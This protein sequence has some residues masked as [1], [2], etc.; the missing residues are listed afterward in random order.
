MTTI[1]QTGR[2]KQSK[3]DVKQNL[4]EV[5]F[6][7]EK[8]TVFKTCPTCGYPVTTLKKDEQG[9]QWYICGKEK[10][11]TLTSKPQEMILNDYMPKGA[12]NYSYDIEGKKHFCPGIFARE[13]MNHVFF[14]TDELTDQTYI[15]NVAK[16]IWEAN[17]EPF[18][19]NLM[20][21]KLKSA[22][23]KHQY[24]EVI[25]NIKAN[26]YENVAESQN[27]IALQN[28]ILNLDTLKIEAPT[29]GNFI[30]SQITP[31]YNL[32]AD[33]PVIK[34]ALLEILGSFW[35]PTIQEYIGYCLYRGMPFHKLLLLIGG[36]NN[37]KSKILALITEF[38]GPK[39]CSSIPL[40]QLC[41]DKFS[42]AQLYGKMSNICADLSSSEI[43]KLG[44]LKLLTGDDYIYARNLYSKG[45]SFKNK[46]KMLFSANIAPQINENTDAVYRRL[47]VIPCNNKFEGKNC[48][49]N[50]LAKMTTPTELSG[51]LNWALEGLKRLLKKGH[52]TNDQSAEKIRT[53]YIRQS[54]PAK[55]FIEERIEYVNDCTQF[56]P[57]L[58]EE[59]IKFCK[60][61]RL[62]TVPQRI[63]TENLKRMIPESG[64]V[65]RGTKKARFWVHNNLRFKKQS[66]N[67]SKINKTINTK[68]TETNRHQRHQ[69]HSLGKKKNHN[70]EV[71]KRVVSAVSPF[72]LVKTIQSKNQH[73]KPDIEKS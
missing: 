48:D 7:E 68:I 40:Q 45:F 50:I 38:L 21:E 25:F 5:P 35:L 4:S 44:P 43:S 63:L 39:N 70:I 24:R 33:C 32:Q 56:I 59:F 72:S 28:G 14:K 46:A 19:K 15:Y 2:T 57:K 65:Q 62:A 71:N 52:F 64:R 42:L 26:S 17:A 55:A 73:T 66:S 31:T 3:F 60:S 12:F 37:G 27:K 11:K 36:G 54:N 29:P 41:E 8:C 6:K 18:I 30:L 23:R 34:K 61:E 9:T 51:L 69:T 13:A 10:C 47:L 22:L 20:A 49:P 1:T 58:Y 67:D 16:G 53:N